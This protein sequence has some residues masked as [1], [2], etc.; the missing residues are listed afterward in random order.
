M[1]HAVIAVKYVRIHANIKV[2]AAA[3][4]PAVLTHAG[5]T[6]KTTKKHGNLRM[7][8]Q[9]EMSVFLLYK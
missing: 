4:V 3:H 1:K 2:T 9:A 8:K 7:I 5:W 6:G